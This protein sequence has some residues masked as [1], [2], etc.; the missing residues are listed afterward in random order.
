[1]RFTH[2]LQLWSID[3]VIYTV[4]QKKTVAMLFLEQL[5]ET[6]TDLN[7]LWHA[8]SQR[9]FRQ[10]TAVCPLRLNSVATLPC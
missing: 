5:H 9:N 3:Q 7:Y 6:L 1:M 10:M 2:A 8:T 4:S